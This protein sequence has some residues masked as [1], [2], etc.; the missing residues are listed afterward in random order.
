MNSAIKTSPRQETRGSSTDLTRSSS[1]RW[2]RRAS[3]V[4]AVLTLIVF[5]VE[6][7]LTLNGVPFISVV[8]AL[9]CSQHRGYLPPEELAEEDCTQDARVVAETNRF[10]LVNTVIGSLLTLLV[11]LMFPAAADIYGRKWIFSFCILGMLINN[12]WSVLMAHIF[13][14]V[15]VESILWA[16]VAVLFGG[17]F[18]VGEA[19]VFTMI[20]DISSDKWRTTWF[21]IA[22]CGFLLGEVIGSLLGGFLLAKS[23][24]L[25]LYI[26]LGFL[27]A[28]LAIALSLPETLHMRSQAPAQTSPKDLITR[29]GQ[30][31]SSI[32]S[33]FSSLRHR[34]VYL[35]IPAASLV[36]PVSSSALFLMIQVLPIRYRSDYS[37]SSRFQA[38]SAATNLAVFIVA[39]PLLSY[40]LRKT[41]VLR[42]DRILNTGSSPFLMVGMLIIAT[43]PNLAAAIAGLVIFTLGAGVPGLSR[44]MIAQVIEKEH[45]GTLFGLLA[46]VEQLGFLVFSLSMTGLFQ[47]GL[48]DG[49]GGSLSYPFYFAFAVLVVVCACSWFARPTAPNAGVRGEA[50]ELESS[51]N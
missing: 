45:L 41:A 5:L 39:L 11:A 49:G 16:N 36:I 19:L 14:N 51:K 3:F 33:T 24:W 26:G 21:Q 32:R 17:G 9:I 30:V 37:E 6:M 25:P 42:R 35:L 7:G 4:V 12:G 2:Y 13:P 48:A 50:V 43:A 27:G 8:T 46:V 18:R 47:K 34:S 10:L 29:I 20:S 44:S 28:G 23:L 38:V 40:W 31:W 22:I 15:S 1:K